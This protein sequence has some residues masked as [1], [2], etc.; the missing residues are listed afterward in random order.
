[1]NKPAWDWGCAGQGSASRNDTAQAARD[2]T[3]AAKTAI[4]LVM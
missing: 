2:N 4:N 3:H 1:M